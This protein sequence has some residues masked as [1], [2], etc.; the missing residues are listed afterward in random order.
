MIKLVTTLILIATV[1]LFYADPPLPK[2]ERVV[3]VSNLDPYARFYAYRQY[4]K[5]R[6]AAFRAKYQARVADA[7]ARQEMKQAN[8]KPVTTAE[9]LFAQKIAERHATE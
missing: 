2:Y 1:T 7:K 3:D 9:S 8:T 5:D 6:R 4:Q